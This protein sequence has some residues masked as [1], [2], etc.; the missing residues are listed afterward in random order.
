MVRNASNQ[1]P[2]GTGTVKER[3]PEDRKPG[4]TPENVGSK[5]RPHFARLALTRA[6]ARC[7]RDALNISLCAVEELGEDAS[8]G[9]RRHPPG[10]GDGRESSSRG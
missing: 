8:D 10:R 3:A 9:G 4:P 1:A 6:K 2:K 5:V 7:L